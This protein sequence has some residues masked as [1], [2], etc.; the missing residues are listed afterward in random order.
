VNTLL[1]KPESS[2]AAMQFYRSSLADASERHCNWAGEYYG[3]AAATRN[4]EFW[5]RRASRSVPAETAPPFNASD[6][7]DEPLALSPDLTLEEIPCI[8][9]EFVSVKLA[10]H[11]PSLDTPVTFVGGCEMS[12]LVRRVRQGMKPMEIALLWSDRVPISTGLALTGWL[13]SKGLMVRARDEK[14][15]KPI[16]QTTAFRV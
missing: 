3:A 4:A 13:I 8:D 10:L 16:R 15:Q 9:G 1:R 14:A 6:L 2:E 12:P 11:H 7:A 5:Q